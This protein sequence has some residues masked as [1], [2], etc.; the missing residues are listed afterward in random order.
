M[1]SKKGRKE[2]H[3]FSFLPFSSENGSVIYFYIKMLIHFLH[4]PRMADRAHGNN[5]VHCR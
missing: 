3:V 4:F 2:N 5:I 1:K